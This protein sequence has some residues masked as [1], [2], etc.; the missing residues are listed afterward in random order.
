MN[1]L[2]TN[3]DGIDHSGIKSLFLELDKNHNVFVMAP[4]RNRSGFG[5]AITFLTETNAKKLE[6][7]IYSLDRVDNN[8]VEGGES[9]TLGLEYSSLKE[10][11]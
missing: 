7:N 6:E 4:D 10:T 2:L 8:A 1:I 3:D 9:L 11:L 5:S